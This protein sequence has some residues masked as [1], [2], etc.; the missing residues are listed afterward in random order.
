MSDLHSNTIPLI[1]RG[2]FQG[3]VL[4][5]KW[6]VL[7]RTMVVPMGELCVVRSSPIPD[8]RSVERWGLLTNQ[9]QDVEKEKLPD[10]L[11]GSH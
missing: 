9:M 11:Q 4:E 1:I 2:R 5:T 7:L 6:E 8:E 10:W 3:T